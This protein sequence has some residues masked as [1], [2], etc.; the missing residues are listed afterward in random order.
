MTTTIAIISLT[1]LAIANSI[2][3][4]VFFS[5]NEDLRNENKILKRQVS[6]FEYLL[7]LDR[8]DAHLNDGS[9]QHWKKVMEEDDKRC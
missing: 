8:F 9:I 3:A 7:T 2:F 1:V 5:A 4:M 6:E